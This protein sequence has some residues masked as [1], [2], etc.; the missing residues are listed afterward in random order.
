MWLVSIDW[1]V[2]LSIVCCLVFLCLVSWLIALSVVGFD[3]LADCFESSWLMSLTYS[4]S[5][6]K[7]RPSCANFYIAR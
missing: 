3:W 2:A 4:D 7:Q 5:G 6:K 1:L